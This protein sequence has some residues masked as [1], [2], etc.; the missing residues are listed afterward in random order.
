MYCETCPNVRIKVTHTYV[1]ANSRTQR[2]VC[3]R[4]ETVY[5][6]ASV[7]VGRETRQGDGA[8][9]LAKNL[10]NGKKKLTLETRNGTC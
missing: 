4:C 1:A 8:Y 6:I 10:E 5:T 7:I 2:A 3:P 9:S